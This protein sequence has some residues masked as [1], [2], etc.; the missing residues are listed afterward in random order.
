[1]TVPYLYRGQLKD[2]YAAY[3]GRT[4]CCL[5]MSPMHQYDSTKIRLN[6]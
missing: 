6:K 2:V 1:M 5:K 4:D 3:S